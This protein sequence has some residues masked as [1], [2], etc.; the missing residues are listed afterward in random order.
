MRIACL[1]P[2]QP[3]L[4]QSILAE[5]FPLRLCAFNELTRALRGAEIH[6]KHLA[7]AD[8]TIY[9]DPLSVASLTRWFGHELRGVRYCTVGR[10]TCNSVTIRGVD[11]V[12]FS[13]AMEQ[14]Q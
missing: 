4:P 9:I 3:P 13:L 6:I 11:V 2:V 14:D 8:N 5:D 10:Q 7:L 12:W 1:S